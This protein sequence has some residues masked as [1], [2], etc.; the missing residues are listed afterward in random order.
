MLD[1]TDI[2]LV[3]E[4]TIWVRV[5]EVIQLRLVCMPV[6]LIWNM[7]L[8]LDILRML[9]AIVEKLT[10]MHRKEVTALGQIAPACLRAVC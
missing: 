2:C 3:T 7:L 1:V 4:Q 9:R 5:S 6:A 8:N 10:S